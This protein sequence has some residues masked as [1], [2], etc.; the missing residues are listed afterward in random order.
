MYF[1]DQKSQ[2]VTTQL[3]AS[4]EIQCSPPPQVQ[5]CCGTHEL[6]RSQRRAGERP[7]ERLGG[8]RGAP[9]APPGL[10]TRTWE[11]VPSP[12]GGGKHR[13]GPWRVRRSFGGKNGATQLCHR[14]RQQRTS[15]PTLPPS[16]RGPSDKGVTFPSLT[17]ALK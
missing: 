7:G 14:T 8:N 5:A 16:R 15:V 17:P 12:P 10:Q 2:L 9:A 13:V 3:S 1:R 6:R 11:V 4:Q